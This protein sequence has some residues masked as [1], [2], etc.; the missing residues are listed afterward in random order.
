[1]AAE[2]DSKFD[3][4]NNSRKYLLDYFKIT[5][6]NTAL[7]KAKTTQ[8]LINELNKYRSNK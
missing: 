3:F 5:D 2:I 4:N 8:K 6:G 7:D 1:M